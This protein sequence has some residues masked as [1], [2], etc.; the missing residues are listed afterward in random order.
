MIN[1][2]AHKDHKQEDAQEWGTRTLHIYWGP[3][4]KE[5]TA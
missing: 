4:P 1:I 2:R 3:A 5:F